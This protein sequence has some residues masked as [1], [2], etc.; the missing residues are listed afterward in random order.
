[1]PKFIVGIFSNCSEFDDYSIERKLLAACELAGVR[2]SAEFESKRRGFDAL[3]VSRARITEPVL[4]DMPRCRVVCRHGQGVDNIDVAAASALGIP[5]CNVP[6]F[7]TEEVSDHALAC[8]LMLGRNIPFYHA[9]LRRERRWNFDIVPA[10]AGIGEMN[11]AILGFGRIGRRLAEKAR[12]LFGRVTAY[13][14]QMDEAMEKSAAERG[15]DITRDLRAL[16]SEADILSLH[17]P[18]DEG[19]RHLIDAEKLAWMKPSACLVN[20]AR[21]AIVD[22]DALNAALENG[23]IAGA[24]VDVLEPDP[25]P[26]GHVLYGQDKCIVTPHIA[27]YS[28]TSIRRM[29]EEAAQTVLAALAGREP[30]NRVN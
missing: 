29:R 17:I 11:L 8:A 21:G 1:M 3:I 5:V 4:R 27:W 7:N 18:L 24:A 15:T 14:A 10:N 9:A 28:A 22:G 26:A 20:C 13:D 12:P 19:S 6:D 2:D 25:P 30:G 23:T 16:V